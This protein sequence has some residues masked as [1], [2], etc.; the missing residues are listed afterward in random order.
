ML[1]S[2]PIILYSVQP[3][4]TL[5]QHQFVF[6][7][8]KRK[9]KCYYFTISL[10]SIMLRC[11]SR[12]FHVSLVAMAVTVLR[13]REV[14]GLGGNSSEQVPVS[15]Q[16]K[17]STNKIS[18]TL[19]PLPFIVCLF[20]CCTFLHENASPVGGT[21]HIPFE[22]HPSVFVLYLIYYRGAASSFR[23]ITTEIVIMVPRCENTA[24][25]RPRA[26]KQGRGRNTYSSNQ[27]PTPLVA[28]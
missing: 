6:S 5:R 1:V 3:T 24:A 28:L 2:K 27:K 18:P 22:S 11:V 13:R 17:T 9:I 8:R 12:L 21:V 4:F 25:L 26:F 7:I 16:Q 23:T 19:P 14:L 10:L 20:V 15:R